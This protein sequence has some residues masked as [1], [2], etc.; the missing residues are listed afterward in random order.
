MVSTIGGSSAWG[1]INAG[2]RKVGA[3]EAAFTPGMT[4]TTA[5]DCKAIV[6]RIIKH[7]SVMAERGDIN[8]R[9]IDY[10]DYSSQ[11]FSIIGF[12]SFF[13]KTPD[14][15]ATAFNMSSSGLGVFTAFEDA[16]TRVRGYCKGG[17]AHATIYGDA[18]IYIPNPYL[19]MEPY[20]GAQSS[21]PYNTIS[22]FKRRSKR[23][24]ASSL[25]SLLSI[26][27]RPKTVVDVAQ[28][29]KAILSLTSTS[30]KRYKLH[31]I[32][33]DAG[34]DKKLKDSLNNVKE[35]KTKKIFKKTADFF[36]GASPHGAGLVYG[37]GVDISTV[38]K[39]VG[40]GVQIAAST[41]KSLDKL[42]PD[43]LKF[44]KKIFDQENH[45]SP[46]PSDES[47]NIYVAAAYI[48]FRATIE[49]A[50]FNHDLDQNT[51]GAARRHIPQQ[52][53]QEAQYLARNK[54][55]GGLLTRHFAKTAYQAQ[56]RDVV[57]QAGAS[58]AKE[59]A[60][61]ADAGPA[62]RIIKTVFSSTY[63]SQGHQYDWLALI[64]EPEGWL[65]LANKLS[66]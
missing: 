1:T 30:V 25:A 58:Y 5:P 29:T 38:A 61:R 13:G 66:I 3:L 49:Q 35:S 6:E 2:P 44:F 15:V 28:L 52:S 26:F 36:A 18:K 43:W 4:L 12:A 64:D 65:A 8:Q 39:Q 59:E 48:H 22:Y 56:R 42:S 14:Q 53:Q 57:E 60:G 46:V 24:T 20:K 40:G 45:N 23:Q 27:L 31:N 19:S 50:G 62:T 55:A 9:I 33:L 34:E 37:Q 47:T 63:G 54:G 11:V 21:T 7:K 32:Q 41:Y 51:T 17:W 10:C 16:Y